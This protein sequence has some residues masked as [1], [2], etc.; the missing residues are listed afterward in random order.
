VAP[1]ASQAGWMDGK[2]LDFV[3]VFSVFRIS[4][5][6]FFVIGIFILITAMKRN[7]RLTDQK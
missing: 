2:A 5:T 1:V 6:V 4:P 3:S 7:E